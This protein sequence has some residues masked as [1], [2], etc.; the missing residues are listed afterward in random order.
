MTEFL[1]T[2]AVRFNVSPSPL[3]D[4]MISSKKTLCLAKS[5]TKAVMVTKRKRM[6]ICR[7]R[8]NTLYRTNIEAITERERVSMTS[9]LIVMPSKASEAARMVMP[10]A[11]RKNGFSWS[12]ESP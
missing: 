10:V 3:M 8:M 6:V 5:K 12:N 2:I 1:S 9:L 7:G 11:G 4:S